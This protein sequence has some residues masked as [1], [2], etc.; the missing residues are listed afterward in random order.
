MVIHTRFDF[1][2]FNR[3]L[4]ATPHVAGVAALIWY[5]FPDCTNNQI[6]NVLIYS[7]EDLGDPS[8]DSSYGW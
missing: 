2:Y 4:Q 6:R 5:H 1:E 8:W 3:L 7:S